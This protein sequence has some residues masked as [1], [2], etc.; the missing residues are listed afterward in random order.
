MIR[1]DLTRPHGCPYAAARRMVDE[2]AADAPALVFYD[3]KHCLTLRSLHEA[4]LLTVVEEPKLR[5]AA[6]TPHFK[7]TVSAPMQ[8]L[9][10][11]RAADRAAK[12]G[13]RP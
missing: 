8:A 13:A 3:G 4:A 6:Y 1:M 7:A 11:R 10:D 9:L 2:G 12:K 5:L